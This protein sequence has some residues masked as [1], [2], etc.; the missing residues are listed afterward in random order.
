MGFLDGSNNNIILDAVLTDT[1]RRFLA[2]GNF[3]IRKFVLSDDEVDYGQIVKY[4]REVG[5]EKII[6][7]TPIFEAVTNQNFSL[8]SRLVSLSSPNIK[9]M[10][11]LE[12]NSKDSQVNLSVNSLQSNLSPS[13]EVSIRQVLNDTNPNA[14]LDVELQD[15]MYSVVMNNE[16]LTCNGRLQFVDSY[17]H[18]TYTVQGRTAATNK[19]TQLNMVLT[20]KAIAAS[21]FDIY[22]DGTK[23]DTSVRVTGMRS[24]ATLDIPVTIEFC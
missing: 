15:S 21:M 2:A 19:T 20:V 5:N 8:N 4:G 3:A 12:L 24:G 7:N 23:I 9:Y 16:F 6:K 13:T 10:P 22:G 14:V 17:N 1:G 11:K 18:A